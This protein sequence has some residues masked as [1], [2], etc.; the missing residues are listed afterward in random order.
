MPRGARAA[1]AEAVLP[2][3]ASFWQLLEIQL[4]LDG[5]SISYNPELSDSSSSNKTAS[6]HA[7]VDNWIKGFFH[8]CKLVKR[9]DRSEGDF[10]KEVAES[11]DVRMFVHKIKKDVVENEEACNAFK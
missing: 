4:E 5:T 6:L 11:E 7:M 9:L 10:L 3:V 1:A 2:Y 8:V